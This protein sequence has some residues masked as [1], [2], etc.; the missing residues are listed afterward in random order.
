MGW[1]GAEHRNGMIDVPAGL[2]AD[3]LTMP[4]GIFTRQDA[5]RV[6]L[7]DKVLIA[8]LRRRMIVRICRAAYMSPETR[9]KGEERRLLA[10]AALRVYDDAA[11]MGGAAVAAH[12]VALFEVPVV[13]TD[14]AR[15]VRREAATAQ[16]RIRPLRDAVVDTAWGPATELAAALVQLTL[17]RGVPAGVA[18]MDDALHRE[19][20]TRE[21]LD[22]EYGRIRRWPHASRVRCALAWSDGDAESV[23]ESITRVI[24]LG[25]GWPVE[26]QVPIADQDGVVFA[27]AD[28]GIAGTRVLLEFDGKVKYSDGGPD[29]LFREKKRED[30]IRAM[31]YVIVRVTWADLFRPERILRAVADALAT[32]A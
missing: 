10:R 11:L 24:L 15:P 32:A 19:L 28:L 2:F 21:E 31:G 14:I 1:R 30:R 7:T 4:D 27:R 6:G 17:D 9:A 5:L 29:A 18:A 13:R 26:S 12:G 20:V 8:G 22:T 16:L 3:L 23:G 25:A